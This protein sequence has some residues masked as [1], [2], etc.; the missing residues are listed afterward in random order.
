MDVFAEIAKKAFERFAFV[1]LDHPIEQFQRS[2]CSGEVIV[3]VLTQ[4]F[5]L[6][7]VVAEIQGSAPIILWPTIWLGDRIALLLAARD[8][9]GH[10][11]ERPQR[12]CSS[13]G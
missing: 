13:T 7:L 9:F 4:I 2:H 6:S 8:E 12:V 1:G 3:E 10:A 11:A 5:H